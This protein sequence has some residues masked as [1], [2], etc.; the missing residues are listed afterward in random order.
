MCITKS[1]D[2]TCSTDLILC[3]QSL[4]IKPNLVHS[5]DNIADYN[6]RNA[7]SVGKCSQVLVSVDK[8]SLVLVSVC[9]CSQVLVSVGKCS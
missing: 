4:N 7:L 8:C 6:T 5:K 1:V 9:K 3:A 2:S